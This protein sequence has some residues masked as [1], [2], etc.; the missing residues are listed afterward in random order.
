M[1]KLFSPY[2]SGPVTSDIFVAGGFPEG[3]GRWWLKGIMTN[4]GKNKQEGT[5]PF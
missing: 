5:Y 3:L 4:K 2:L 1:L